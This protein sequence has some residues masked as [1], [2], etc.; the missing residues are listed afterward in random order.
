MPDAFI[1]K[2]TQNFSITLEADDAANNPVPLAFAT[3][4]QWSTSDST[5]LTVSANEDGSIAGFVTTGKLGDVQIS[6]QAIDNDGV[7]I[8]GTLPVSVVASKAVK[9]VLRPNPPTD[10]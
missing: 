7:A 10:K 3:P 4:P 2:D 9:F 5:I 8:I 6:V 1:I